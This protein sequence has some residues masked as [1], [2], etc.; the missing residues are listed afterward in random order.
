MSI[1]RKATPDD[2]AD[3]IEMGQKFIA[4]SEF[5]GFVHPSVAEMAQTVAGI[6]QNGVLFVIDEDGKAVGMLAG[7]LT[8]FWMSP[9]NVIATELLW[10]VNEESR[11]GRG[12]IMLV[13]AFEEWA[14][15]QNA[16]AV[17]ISD[18]IIQGESPVGAL[19]GRMGYRMVERSHIKE[20]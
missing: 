16:V 6:I 8:P 4:Y 1:I 18:L 7:I 17:S 11:A 9:T 20:L 14:R 13:K 5:R 10:W 15:E 2:I 12:G 3:I 19:V